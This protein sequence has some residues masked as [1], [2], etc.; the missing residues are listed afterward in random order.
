MIN[1][2]LL[3]TIK[4]LPAEGISEERKGVLLTLRDYIRAMLQKNGE[5]ALNFICTH[6]S[7]RS[8][9]SQVW[10]QMAAYYY[11]YGKAV[12]CY[13]GGT[14]ATALYPAVAGVLAENG[15]GVERLSEGDNP[16]YAIKYAADQL[17]VTGFSKVYD[18]P[19]NPAEGF[20]AVMTCSQA[21]QDCPYVAGASIRVSLPFEDPKLF[22]ETDQKMEKYH[23]RS[24]Q[25]G[26]EMFWVF[27]ALKSQKEQ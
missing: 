11:G 24:L 4:Q 19:F 27:E 14:E 22:D 26:A 9:L 18:H 1:E 5:V 3:D 16:V 23:E 25:I 15:F 17:P 12:T 10:A 20:I 7:R 6:N 13:S 21:D 8:H 2:H